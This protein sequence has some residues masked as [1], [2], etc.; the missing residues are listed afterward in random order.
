MAAIESTQPFFIKL[1]APAFA[2]VGDVVTYTYELTNDGN[3]TLSGP[4]AVTDDQIAVDCSAAAAIATVSI[5]LPIIRRLFVA[6][7]LPQLKSGWAAI[8]TI[9]RS[10]GRLA[11]LFGGSTAI[12]F[13][14]D[15]AAIVAVAIQN[16]ALR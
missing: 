13:T 7:V 3:T 14:L 2:V 6:S 11:M 4:F 5:G 10:P 1:K 9:G 16:S 15:T 12:T 8:R